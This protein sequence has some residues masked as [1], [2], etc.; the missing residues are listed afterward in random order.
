ML[1]HRR[2]KRIRGHEDRLYGFAYALTQDPALAEDMVQET[3]TRALAAARL[4]EDPP[5]VRAWL[6]RILRNAVIDQHR[7]RHEQPLDDAAIDAHESTVDWAA[8]DRMINQVTVRAAFTT[9]KHS[10]QEIL[11]LVDVAGMTYAEAA[12]TLDVPVGTV[13]SRLSRA[14]DSL[15]RAIRQGNVRPLRR[16]AERRS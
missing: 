7:R 2:W 14:R 1:K 11:A 16:P 9:L 6:F 3:L 13:M 8:V 4:P 12:L 10:Q 5:A 15:A